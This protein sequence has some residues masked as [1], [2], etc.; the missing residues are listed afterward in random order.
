MLSD[1]MAAPWPGRFPTMHLRTPKVVAPLSTPS[2]RRSLQAAEISA[3][4][5]KASALPLGARQTA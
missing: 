5:C 4:K 1:D 2:A 3:P